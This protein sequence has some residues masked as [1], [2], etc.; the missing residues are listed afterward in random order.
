MGGRQGGKGFATS[1][2][3]GGQEAAQPKNTEERRK[4]EEYLTN[5]WGRERGREGAV[6]EGG[7]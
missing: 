6:D 7:R 3:E 1:L 4:R 5:H 2:C